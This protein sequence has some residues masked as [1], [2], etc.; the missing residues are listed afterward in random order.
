MELIR[1]SAMVYVL[2]CEWA[3][4]ST[5][6]CFIWQVLKRDKAL[7]FKHFLFP[8]IALGWKRKA[9]LKVNTGRKTLPVCCDVNVTGTGS[10]NKIFDLIFR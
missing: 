4:V 2:T 3:I 5:L 7:R 10:K 1:V 8:T 6:D 9:C